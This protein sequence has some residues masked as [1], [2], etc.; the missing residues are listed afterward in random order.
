[1]VFDPELEQFKPRPRTTNI[2]RDG[3]KPDRARLLALWLLENAAQVNAI[4]NV[5]IVFNCAGKKAS[6]EM[7]NR[8][9]IDTDRLLK[10]DV[11]FLEVLS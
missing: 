6:V 3:A 8:Q 11:D 7:T 1:L 5:Q 4:E 10:I 9:K 2:D